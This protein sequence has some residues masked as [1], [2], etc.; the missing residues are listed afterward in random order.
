[1]I[2]PFHFELPVTESE[3]GYHSFEVPRCLYKHHLFTRVSCN[4]QD[5]LLALSQVVSTD[6]VILNAK[7]A[8]VDGFLCAY[9]SRLQPV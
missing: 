3:H 4:L 5:V 2:E 9:S 6:E 7:N 8:L 1:M